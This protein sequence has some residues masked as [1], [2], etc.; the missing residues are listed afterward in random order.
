LDIQYD[1]FPTENSFEANAE[2]VITEQTNKLANISEKTE[3]STVLLNSREA[4][5]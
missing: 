3:L 2:S 1:N 5:L 4:S